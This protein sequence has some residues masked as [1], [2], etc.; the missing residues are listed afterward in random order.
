VPVLASGLATALTGRN[1]TTLEVGLTKLRIRFAGSID[2]IPD[3]SSGAFVVLPAWALAAQPQPPNLLLAVGP[4]LDERKLAAASS[5]AMLGSTVTFR[6][7]I[8]AGLVKAP[9]PHGANTAF[10]EVVAAAAGFSL[11]ILLITLVLSARSREFTV[12]RL[13][14][15]GLSQRQARWMVAVEMLPQILAATIGG[16][17]SAWALALLVS[18][19]IDLAPFTGTGAGV[20]V[21][22]EPVPL[23]AAAGGLVVLALAALA[24][25][26]IIADRRGANRALRVSD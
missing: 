11:L 3:V 14:V 15:M 6:S 13:R 5:L 10:A 26:V 12:A 17:A 21:R 18:P 9:L 8:L 1:Q 7:H 4:H 22:V 16:V 23:V 20:P 25:Q 24:A 2:A 19:S